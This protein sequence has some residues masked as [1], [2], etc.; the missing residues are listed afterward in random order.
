M[1]VIEL[2]SKDGK[3]TE[4]YYCSA[5][6][7]VH[8][9]KEEA[10]CC[11]R[12][13]MCKKELRAGYKIHCESCS[14]IYNEEQDRLLQEKEKAVFDKATEATD[15]E[16]VW[17]NESIYED[18]ESIIDDCESV[19]LEPPEFVFAMKK[20]FFDGFSLYTNTE[21]YDENVMCEDLEVEKLL[22]GVDELKKAFDDFNQKNK[23]TCVFWEA[24]RT[25]KVRVIEKKD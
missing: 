11:C 2:Y 18:L 19:G 24:D 16:Y 4:I 10:D 13:N 25:K 21:R 7:C 17:H 1:K 5:C 20:V 6:K 22:V 15:F 8:R 12:C 14:K 23:N 3:S 9:T